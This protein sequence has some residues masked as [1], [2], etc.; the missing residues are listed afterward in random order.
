MNDRYLPVIREVDLLVAEA[1]SLTA[2]GPQFLI[3]HRYG[4][5]GVCLAGEEVAFVAL[6]HRSREYP[7]K[8]SISEKLL[9]EALA[10]NRQF[11]QTARQIEGYIRSEKFF[12]RHGANGAQ[13]RLARKVC[14]AAVKV[15]IQRL[16]L[17]LAATF[18]E[19]GL[20][21]DPA[22]VLRTEQTTGPIGYR[23]SA[24]LEWSH[25]PSTKSYC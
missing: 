9:F 21:L 1:A 5:D 25:L 22:C 11:P 17:A 4:R 13:P 19:A 24:T 6:R 18:A 23:L 8:I 3:G 16:R 7:L 2:A 14:R 10:R 15:H 12:A 20:R